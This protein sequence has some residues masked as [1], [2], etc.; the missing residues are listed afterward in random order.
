MLINHF[1]RSS[2]WVKKRHRIPYGFV[3]SFEPVSLFT[4]RRTDTAD[5]SLSFTLDQRGRIK[6]IYKTQ[7][8][9]LKMFRYIE[10]SESGCTGM[11]ASITA[12]LE[13]GLVEGTKPKH[14]C[15]LLTLSSHI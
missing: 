6:D 3:V 2:S 5:T 13:E 4:A 7:D 12:E 15:G 14:L 8:S 9:C 1:P 10:R 11:H